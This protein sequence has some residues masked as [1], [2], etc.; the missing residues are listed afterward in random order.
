MPA[1]PQEVTSLAPCVLDVLCN[2][3]LLVRIPCRAEYLRHAQPERCHQKA[4][5]MF[6][7]ITG[8]HA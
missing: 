1:E 7:A 3:F 8:Q 5:S 2:S 6:Q 4:T